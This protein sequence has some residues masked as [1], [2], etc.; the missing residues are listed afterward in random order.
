MIKNIITVTTAVLVIS[1]L[2]AC[3][4]APEPVA[5]NPQLTTSATGDRISLHVRDQRA[6]NHVMR[7]ETDQTAEFATADPS[8]ASLISDRLGER[9]TIVDNANAQLEVTI[10]DALFVIKQGSL[11]HDT[12]HNIRL[13]TTLTTPETELSTTFRG[14]RES[15]GPLRADI[16]RI[17]REFGVLLADVLNDLVNDDSLTTRIQSAQ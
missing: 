9:W 13:Q 2:A 10:V 7:L 4:S 14:S 17:E 16:K 6:Q 3:Q 5:L 1:L 8:L 11:R 12:V 15:N